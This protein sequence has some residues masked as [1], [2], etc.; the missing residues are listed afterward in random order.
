MHYR[1]IKDCFGDLAVNEECRAVILTGAGKN[2]S[3]GL[4]VVDFAQDFFSNASSDEG[5]DV[6]RK[7]MKFTG[8]IKSMQD[9]FTALEKVR[10]LPHPT[11]PLPQMKY[12]SSTVSKASDSRGPGGMCWRRGGHDQCL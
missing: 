3:A 12:L 9:S 11:T 1:E 2:F 6:A 4:D 7:A 5:V 10:L 8:V